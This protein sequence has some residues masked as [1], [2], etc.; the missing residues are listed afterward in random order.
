M[1]DKQ[2]DIIPKAYS[3]E[4]CIAYIL[5]VWTQVLFKA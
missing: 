1:W 3:F 4:T 5:I 2:I